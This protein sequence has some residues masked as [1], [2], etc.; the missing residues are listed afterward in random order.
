MFSIFKK[1]PNK[2]K[3]QKQYLKLMEQWHELS[4]QNR[5]LSD[6]KYAEAQLILQKIEE[7]DIIER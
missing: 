7:L 5:S 6:Q 4:T 1:T 3:L 2:Q